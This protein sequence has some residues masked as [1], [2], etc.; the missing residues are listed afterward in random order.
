MTL[1]V[2][3]DHNSMII[4]KRGWKNLGCA[5][6]MLSGKRTQMIQR[7]YGIISSPSK[8]ENNPKSWKD[9]EAVILKWVSCKGMN[10]YVEIIHPI[11][12]RYSFLQK[13]KASRGWPLP[14]SLPERISYI[15]DE[16][17]FRNLLFEELQL[18]EKAFEV[19]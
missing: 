5:S 17:A 12:K 11:Q 18:M 19:F 10:D 1:N 4:F 8:K 9:V 16:D 3:Y 13:V 2:S 7:I 6:L 15:K 14:S